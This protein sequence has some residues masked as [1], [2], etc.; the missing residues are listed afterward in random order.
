MVILRLWPALVAL[1]PL[2]C[3][4]SV[5][6]DPNGAEPYAR[7]LGALDLAARGDDK[8]VLRLLEDPHPLVRSGAITALVQ[9][10]KA[11]YLPQ[12]IDMTYETVLPGEDASRND[13]QV[14]SDACRALAAL[15]DPRGVPPLIGALRDGAVEVRR[16]AALSLEPFAERQD[17]LE[18]LVNALPR[19]LASGERPAANEETSA[20]VQHNAHVVLCRAAN[21]ADLPRERDPWLE[22]LK[23]RPK[24]SV[25]GPKPD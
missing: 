18:A 22:W 17:V 4:S 12:L 7:Y 6:P 23:Q 3:V 9:L 1:T 11:E 15:R 21:R 13:P 2:A 16:T 20:A 24:T 19:R 14:R 25:Q 10:G 8:G 5:S